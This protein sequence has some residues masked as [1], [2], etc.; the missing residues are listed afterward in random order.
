LAISLAS[1]IGAFSGYVYYQLNFKTHLESVQHEADTL[2][3]LTSSYV[4]LYSKIRS[5]SNLK[6]TPVPASF[7]AQANQ[8]F[9]E[10][11]KGDGHFLA[12][13]VGLPD[14]YIAT[15]P[16][17]IT[18]SAKLSLMANNLKTSGVAEIIEHEGKSVLRTMY[19]SIATQEACASCHNEIQNPVIPWKKGDVMG[20]YVIDRSVQ[21]TKN[22]YAFFAVVTGFLVTLTLLSLFSAIRLYRDLRQRAGELQQLAL[23]DPLTGCVNRRALDD[24]VN[25]VPKEERDFSAVLVLDIDHFKQINDTH[26]HAIGDQVLVWFAKRVRSQLRKNDVLARVGGEEFTLYLPNISEQHAQEVAERIRNTIGTEA[27]TLGSTTVNITVSI[28]AVHTSK[29]PN[30]ELSMYGKAADTLLYLA[31][32]NGRNRVMWPEVMQLKQEFTHTT[33]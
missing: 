27:M 33:N 10:K 30:Q 25:S 8:S 20:A 22:R 2:L 21:P 14:R 19:P 7:R 9:E 6:S 1:V 28:G 26:G 16:T 15:P 24:I 29:A 11:Q 17:D 13:M 3:A 5:N 12:R 32:N 31:K 23:T 4:N 18:M